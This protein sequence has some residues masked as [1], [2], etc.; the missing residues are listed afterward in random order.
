MSN[1]FQIEQLRIEALLTKYKTVKEKKAFLDGYTACINNEKRKLKEE[2]RKL[3]KNRV[4]PL[5]KRSLKL[6]E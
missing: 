5:K 2:P 1:T 4:N 3:R 6:E